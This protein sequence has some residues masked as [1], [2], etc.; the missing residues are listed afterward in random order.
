LGK[1]RGY[2]TPRIRNVTDVRSIT[3]WSRARRQER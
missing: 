3:L 1:L 2:R